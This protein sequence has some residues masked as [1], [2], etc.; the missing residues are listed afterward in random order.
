MLKT[1]RNILISIL[2]LAIL[3]AGVGVGYTLFF[4]NNDDNASASKDINENVTQYSPLPKPRKPSAKT[5]E[6]ASVE[7]LISPVKIGA[8]TSITIKTKAGSTCDIVVT[9]NNIASKDSGLTKKVADDYGNITWTWTITKTVPIGTWPAKVTCTYAKK[10]AVVI[11]N[12]KVI[13]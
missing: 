3:F 1:V 10:S 6:S 4:G 7:S 5:A 2:V 12:L 13:N 9:Y 11:G 8:N